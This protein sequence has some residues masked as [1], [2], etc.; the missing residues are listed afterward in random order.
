MLTKMATALVPAEDLR[1]LRLP[2][3]SITIHTKY[4]IFHCYD[5]SLAAYLFFVEFASDSDPVSTHSQPI[6]FCSLD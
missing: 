2:Y 1:L 6:L 5:T 3:L 4:R